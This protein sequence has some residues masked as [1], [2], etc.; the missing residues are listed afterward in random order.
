MKANL[1]NPLIMVAALLAFVFVTAS[2]DKNDSLNDDVNTG[3][4]ADVNY[5]DQVFDELDDL[6]DEANDAAESSEALLKSGGLNKFYH[7][8]D[9]ATVTRTKTGDSIVTVVNYGDTNCLSEDEHYRRGKVIITHTGAIWDEGAEIEIAFDNFFVDDNQIL[10]SK[11][12]SRYINNN[13]QP[14]SN[15]VVEGS[16]ILANNAGTITRSA[17]RVRTITEGY[18]TKY[19]WDDVIEVSGNAKTTLADGTVVTSTIISPLMRKNEQGCF[20]YFIKGT[21]EIVKGDA[22]PITIDYGDGEC[23]NLAEVTQDGVTITIELT[24]KHK[25]IKR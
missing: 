8:G 5:A 13:G 4:I 23:D 12:I 18:T 14:E 25:L 17:N 15:I 2:C 22:S 20:K 19:R 24:R 11:T 9:C 21:R 10:G 3:G 7:I 6:A 1:R 16:M